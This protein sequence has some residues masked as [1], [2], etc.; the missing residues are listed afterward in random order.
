MMDQLLEEARQHIGLA[1]I[2]ESEVSRE[3]HYEAARYF[4]VGA[5]IASGCDLDAV[6]RL[7]QTILQTVR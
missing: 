7:T 5:A 1:A 2:A 3:R 6:N 4:L